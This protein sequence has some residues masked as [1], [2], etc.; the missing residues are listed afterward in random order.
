MPSNDLFNEIFSEKIT[1]E[2]INSSEL[3]CLKT[4]QYKLNMD[5]SYSILQI[6]LTYGVL[7][8]NECSSLKDHYVR[9]Y[10]LSEDILAYIYDGKEL[11]LTPLDFN[12][13]NYI[14]LHIACAVVSV[15]RETMRLTPW[16]SILEHFYKLKLDHFK[17]AFHYVK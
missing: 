12:Y 3:F 11:L 4:I 14:P 15:A 17:D 1:T 9:V 10:E 2:D 5:T 7:F 6:L 8:T 16:C 13:T